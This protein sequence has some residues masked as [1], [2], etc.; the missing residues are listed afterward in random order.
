MVRREYGQYCGVARA[1]AIVG[2]RWALLIV[3]DLL[4]APRRFSDLRR[5]LPKI[6]TNVLTVRLH[7][8]EEAGVIRRRAQPRPAGGTVYELTD[9]GRDLEPVVLGL[10]RWGARILAQPCEGEIVTPDS[11]IMALRSTFQPE[12]AHGSNATY[13]LRANDVVIHARITDGTLTVANGPL[14]DAAL[15]ITANGPLTPLLAGELTA[16]EAVDQGLLVIDG[17]LAALEQFA[18]IFRIE[19]APTPVTT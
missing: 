19:S 1:L 9:F 18:T 15:T 14:P 17:E 5:G 12:A 7:E 4:V 8:L 3:R 6:P 16:A 2:E 11:L 10:G 13:E